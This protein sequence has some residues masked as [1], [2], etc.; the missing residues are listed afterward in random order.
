[1]FTLKRSRQF[2][3]LTLGCLL[4][5][6]VLA[7][8]ISTFAGSGTSGH[9]DGALSAAQFSA[10]MGLALDAVSS[11]LYLS[12]AH[13]IRSI[14]NG[15]VTT[16][17]GDG[18][19]STFNLPS[20]LALDNVGNLYIIDQNNQSLKRLELVTGLV[21][22]VLDGTQ[23]TDPQ[24][25]TV[26][27][28]GLIYLADAGANQILTVDASVTPATV[29]PLALD[30]TATAL[31]SPQALA[32][33]GTKLYVAEPL[34]QRVRVID[35]GVVPATLFTV[36]GGTGKTFYNFANPGI[37]GVQ[38]NLKTPTDLGLDSVGNLY[39]SDVGH[40]RVLK[41]DVA[42]QVVTVVAGVGSSLGIGGFSGDGGQGRLAEIDLP[43]GLVVDSAGMLYFTDSNNQRVRSV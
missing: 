40:N 34:A 2:I 17:A 13:S 16:L 10:P 4:N 36:A 18:T 9:Q 11:T 6:V 12:D 23:L 32:I 1:M 14:Q 33:N 20:D 19:T 27:S 31:S 26:D 7:G 24:G 21:T 38:A 15:V 25:L 35:L 43:M 8:T 42:T 37:T 30:A 22:V 29:T 3:A 39:I 5:G 41:W 28:N